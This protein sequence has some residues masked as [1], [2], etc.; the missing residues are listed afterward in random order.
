MIN[1]VTEESV[2]EDLKGAYK[3]VAEQV[4]ILS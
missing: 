3:T 4:C 1:N 2:F